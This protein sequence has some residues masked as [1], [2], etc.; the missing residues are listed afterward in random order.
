MRASKR[1]PK[2]QLKTLDEMKRQLEGK[3]PEQEGIWKNFGNSV[4]TVITNF[5][6]DISKSLWDGDISWG[7]KGKTLLKSLGQAVTSS[8]IE[9][10]TA[11]IG[12]FIKGAL[13]DLLGGEGFGGVWDSIKGIGSS[14]GG[15]FGGGGGG[16]A[17]PGIPG[18]GGGG[19]IGGAVS[20]AAGWIGAISGAVSAVSGIIG[21][22]QMKGMNETLALI[23]ESTRY[24][25]IH[26]FYILDKL[27]EYIPGIKDIHSYL[28]EHQAPAFG[29]L[30]FE[31]QHASLVLDRLF[32]HGERANEARYGQLEQM[33]AGIERIALGT[34]RSVTMN[35][36][37]TD[38]EIVAARIAQQLRLQGAAG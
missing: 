15:I 35:L 37:G 24:S 9:P 12:T 36:N 5:A 10:A 2:E 7:E 26:L 6:Q 34:E 4:S 27:N 19:A 22:F 8:F 13:A 33:I 28:Y 31:A 11:A 38:P 20:G 3:L 17:K 29:E 21:N 30:I 23:K 18:G 16:G 25:M 32:Y 1:F 14:V